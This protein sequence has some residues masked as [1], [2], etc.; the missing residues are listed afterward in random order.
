MRIY[1]NFKFVRGKLDKIWNMITLVRWNIKQSSSKI[2]DSRIWIILGKKFWNR[3]KNDYLVFF[4]R[5]LSQSVCR[6]YQ[7]FPFRLKK[8][9]KKGNDFDVSHLTHVESIK[10][11]RFWKCVVVFEST[12]CGTYFRFVC[13]SVNIVESCWVLS[14]LF[15]ALLIRTGCNS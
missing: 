5:A 1:R 8:L 2:N 4:F 3:A 6:A 7:T 10:L 11:F 13:L 9:M 15:F 14:L 12:T